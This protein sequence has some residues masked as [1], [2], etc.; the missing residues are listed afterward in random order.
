LCSPQ[1]ART[2]FGKPSF[3]AKDVNEVPAHEQIFL[4][5]ALDWLDVYDDPDPGVYDTAPL[6]ETMMRA[7]YARR[8][9]AWQG[10][11]AERT[12]REGKSRG[13]KTASS[14]E[15]RRF[16]SSEQARTAQKPD[17]GMAKEP[18]QR[19]RL[20]AIGK[21][22]GNW[23]AFRNEGCFGTWTNGHS[24]SFPAKYSRVLKKV[25]SSK[26][27][28]AEEQRELDMR[29]SA[30]KHYIGRSNIMTQIQR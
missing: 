4:A 8:A 24:I 12:K 23:I 3:F 2:R 22:S 9:R 21:T 26:T 5:E 14:G 7:E 18:V 15:E 30:A 27:L 6:K 19:P 20:K 1:C 16:H 13:D 11:I 17:G 29:E 28:G 10:I 25:L